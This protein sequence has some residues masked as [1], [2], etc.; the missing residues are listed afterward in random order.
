MHN[1]LK[2]MSC[3][4]NKLES[5]LKRKSNYSRSNFKN[6]GVEWKNYT[7]KENEYKNKIVSVWL[8]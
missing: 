1:A 2:E 8:V 6:K 4:Y 5:K 7:K 3:I